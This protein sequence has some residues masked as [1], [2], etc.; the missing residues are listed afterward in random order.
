M[1]YKDRC[2]A[3]RRSPRYR[4][5]RLFLLIATIVFACANLA[6]VWLWEETYGPHR[7]AD[8]LRAVGY[9]VAAPAVLALLAW[10]ALRF[11]MPAALSEDRLERLEST[12]TGRSGLSKGS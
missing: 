6:V 4:S 3:L 11:V 12:D 5:I 8:L 10:A 9:S 7:S 1:N 2:R